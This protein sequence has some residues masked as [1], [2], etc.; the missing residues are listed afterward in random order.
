MEQP[1]NKEQLFIELGAFIKIKAPSNSEL[2]D[3]TYF[4]QYLD[5][6]QVDLLNVDTLEKNTNINRW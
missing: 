1:E 4:I 6:S 3:K 2:N 5:D